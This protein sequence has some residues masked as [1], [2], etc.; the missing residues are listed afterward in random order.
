[1]VTLTVQMDNNTDS[2][3]NNMNGNGNG[4]NAHDNNGNNL[5]NGL[6]GG[7]H[8]MSMTMSMS[9]SPHASN[10]RYIGRSQ[11]GKESARDDS[12]IGNLTILG[13]STRVQYASAQ[14]LNQFA[15]KS[16]QMHRSQSDTSDSSNMHCMYNTNNMNNMNSIH[17]SNIEDSILPSLTRGNIVEVLVVLNYVSCDNAVS[18]SPI[19]P[20]NSDILESRKL[21]ASKDE[22]IQQQE[23]KQ[24]SDPEKSS[25]IMSDVDKLNVVVIEYY[26][27]MKIC[28]I[29]IIHHRN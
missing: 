4:D 23:L 29:K 8:S 3:S 20:Y 13:G 11:N 10:S 9:T 12:S 17:K 2:N 24:S 28:G 27:H 1:M 5:N 19:A 21:F 22:I 18:I 14:L 6:F 25:D 26:F 16:M 15:P 7:G